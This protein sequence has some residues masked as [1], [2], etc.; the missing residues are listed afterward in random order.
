MSIFPRIQVFFRGN[1]FFQPLPPLSVHMG[2]HPPGTPLPIQNPICHLDVFPTQTTRIHIE[3]PQGGFGERGEWGQNGQGAGSM[4]SKKPGSREEFR[5]RGAE[6][7]ILK[8]AGS[9]DPPLQSL[10][11]IVKTISSKYSALIFVQ[12]DII[13]LHD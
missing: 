5:E 4:A 3:A 10:I 11:H 6:D 1:Y 12:G 9:G 7:Q 8:G 2:S 13:R